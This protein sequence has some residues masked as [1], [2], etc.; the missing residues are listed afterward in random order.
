MTG[1]QRLNKILQYLLGCIPAIGD[2]ELNFSGINPSAKYPGTT[3]EQRAQG[4]ALVG[5]G[6]NGYYS[7]TARQS[8]GADSVTLAE[9]QIPPHTHFSGWERKVY[10]AG[11]TYWANYQASE[12]TPFNTGSAGGGQPHE[13]RPCS[14]ALYVWERTA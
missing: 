11:S 4:R 1:M 5:V 3:W 8:F 6:S 7:Y 10:A 2:V 12:G 14:I 9:S 13:N